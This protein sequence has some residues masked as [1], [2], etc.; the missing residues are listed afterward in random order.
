MNRKDFLQTAA[1]LS[2]F[3]LLQS[4]CKNSNTISGEIVGA[5]SNVGHLLRNK[6][7]Y[8]PNKTIEI[9]TV[10]VGGGVTG[11]SAARWLKK[12]NYHNFLLFELDKNVGGNAAYGSNQISKYPW[13]AHYVPLPNNDLE[14]Y[15]SFLKEANCVID[16]KNNLPVYNEEYLCAEPQE[17]LYINGIWQPGLV[18]NYG[19]NDIDKKQIASFLKLMEEF[20]TAK[21]KDGKFAFNIPVDTSSK[22]E[23]FTKLDELT[24]QQ[25]L[26]QNNFTSK[27]LHEYINY[28][29]KDDFG[30]EHNT[31]SAW[32]G[33]HYF[34]ARKGKAANANNS[35][36]LTWPEG[37]GF[38]V[39]NLKTNTQQHIRT[40]E[41]VLSI[42]ILPNSKVEVVTFQPTTKLCIAYQTKQCIVATPQFVN[43]KLLPWLQQRNNLIDEK[44]S[45]TP[46]MVANLQVQSLEEKTGASLSWDNVIHNGE[47]LGYTVANHQL[48]SLQQ[49]LQNIT[50]YKPL[51]N[52]TPKIARQ[53]AYATTYLQW[54]EIVFNELQKIHPNIKQATKT[55]NVMLWGHAM[56]NPL[57]GVITDD[58]RAELNKSIDN[59]IH[60]AHTD[61]AGI[62]IFEEGFYQGINA[63]KKV[64]SNV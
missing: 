57:P 43:K 33:I 48:I 39:N 6:T 34:A 8:K 42:K 40:N 61:I 63:A 12:N 55:F 47:A 7:T 2:G 41:L 62:S 36:V 11:L 16:F 58:Y 14:E 32:V 5:N 59:K 49:Q 9:D 13:G 56:A 21:G 22:D 20:K 35:D 1:I 51:T 37:N 4:A 10:I 50:Y 60:F 15:L 52:D 30:T 46:W 26:L 38:F 17:R 54:Q 27:Y 25:W 29:T 64:L 18:P 23:V 19:L 45:Y 31:I 28:C 3:G 24:M 53:K 44:L